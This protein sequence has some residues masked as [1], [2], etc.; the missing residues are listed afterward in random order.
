MKDNR[1]DFSLTLI[2]LC[3]GLYHWT[4]EGWRSQ[5]IL[6]ERKHWSSLEVT[7]LE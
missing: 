1:L 5:S 2:Q 7:A 3:L 4:V 6:K